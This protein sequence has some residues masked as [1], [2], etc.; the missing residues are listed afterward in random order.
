MENHKEKLAIF[1][2]YAKKEGFK[3]FNHALTGLIASDNEN[4]LCQFVCEATDLVQQEAL[5][6]AS[7]NISMKFKDNYRELDMNDDWTEPDKQ[8][9][10]NEENKVK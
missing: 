7:E 6:R 9:I 5:K 8:S 1:D 4:L 3:G 2:Q 10:L